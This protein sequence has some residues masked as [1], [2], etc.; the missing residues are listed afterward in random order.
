MSQTIDLK[1]L[2]KFRHKEDHQ[3]EYQSVG[4]WKSWKK[5]EK[6]RGPLASGPRQPKA[7]FPASAHPRARGDT[8]VAR[9]PPTTSRRHCRPPAT[10]RSSGHTETLFS[11][12]PSATA[13]FPPHSALPL[14]ALLCS[15]RRTLTTEHR[16]RAPQSHAK[17]T[18]TLRHRPS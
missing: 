1:N 13:K 12:S 5:S 9:S 10:S 16:P 8:A 17:P 3:L 11:S 4:V 18:M 15:K 2:E 6:W 7:A 14:I